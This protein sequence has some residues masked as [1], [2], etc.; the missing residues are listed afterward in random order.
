VL[1][2]ALNQMFDI[3]TTRT[4]ATRMHPP[5]VIYG[6]LLALALLGA[7]FAGAAMA[8][9]R[10]RN[11]LHVIGFAAMMAASVYLILDLEFP[12]YGLIRID[13]MDQLLV[14]VRASFD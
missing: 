12:R 6:M 7:V 11:P 9:T 5:M 10:T 14:D 13:P 3:V 1:L 8:G 4:A 2:P